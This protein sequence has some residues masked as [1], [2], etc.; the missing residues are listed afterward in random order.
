MKC[1]AI[2][3]GRKIIDVPS[4]YTFSYMDD[5]KVSMYKC[6]NDPLVGKRYCN[7]HI[8]KKCRDWPNTIDAISK[9]KQHKYCIYCVRKI[10]E[11][12]KKKNPPQ[13]KSIFSFPKFNL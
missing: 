10:Y 11:E 12:K 1:E 7:I 5:A 13:P 6:S 3:A 8:C 9:S 2:Y 4:Y